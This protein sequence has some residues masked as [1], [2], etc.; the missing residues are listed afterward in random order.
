MICVK[1]K[2]ASFLKGGIKMKYSFEQINRFADEH[3]QKL[4]NDEYRVEEL[5][6]DKELYAG[7]TEAIYPTAIKNTNPNSRL[8]KA[9]YED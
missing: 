6:N 1:M 7:E 2:S 5:S 4:M 9:T 3:V 8:F